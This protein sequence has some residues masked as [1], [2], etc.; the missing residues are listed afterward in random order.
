MS[1]A[2]L[3]LN[4][5]R[6]LQCPAGKWGRLAGRAM[7]LANRQPNRIAIE[8]LQVR[9]TDTV[10]ELGFGPGRGIKGLSTLAPQG[11][12]LGVDRSAEMLAFASRANRQAIAHGKVPL[13]QGRFEALPWP[14]QCADKI[15]AVNVVYFFNR[16][17]EEI[18]EAKRML[19]P[20]GVMAIYATDRSTMS[21]WKFSGPDTHSLFDGSE[22]RALVVRGGFDADDVSVRRVTL[23]FGI[24][25]LIAIATAPLNRLT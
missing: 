3:W 24:N 7:I 2:T 25:G 6:Q 18:R 10:L 21:K 16:N 23:P 13:C 5:G 22:L 20:G 15:L 17:G 9:P 1:L 8:A 14:S 4:A 19:R 11:L 12:V